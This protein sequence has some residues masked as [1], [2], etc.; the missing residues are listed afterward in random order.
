[1]AVRLVIGDLENFS[2]VIGV[3]RAFQLSIC[4]VPTISS[5]GRTSPDFLI[6]NRLLRV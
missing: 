2:F 5:V 4:L 1:L 6:A 3:C